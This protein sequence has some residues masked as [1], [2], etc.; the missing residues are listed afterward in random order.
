MDVAK[1]PRGCLI[2]EFGANVGDHHPIFRP[3][4]Q[5]DASW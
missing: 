4:F 3:D 2:H 1:S 5:L